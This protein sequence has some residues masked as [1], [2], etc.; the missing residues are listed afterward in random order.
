[1]TDSLET[2]PLHTVFASPPQDGRAIRDEITERLPDAGLR[3]AR[4]PPDSR[5]LIPTAD[6]AVTASLSTD[7]LDRAGA[8]EWVRAVSSGVDGYPLDRL[9]EARVALTSAAGSTA[10]RSPS[11]CWSTC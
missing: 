10:S 11:R 8:L 6:V 9:R 2:P 5:A 1:V 7:L 3:V 4:T